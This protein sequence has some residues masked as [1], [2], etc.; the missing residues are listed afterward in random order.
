MKI[1]PAWS[2]YLP[3]LIKV[4]QC[5]EGPVLELGTGLVSTPVLH[6]LCFD[7][8]R[9]LVSYDDPGTELQLIHD[10]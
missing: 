2:S 8:G 5:S 10:L 6:W 7:M 9:E 4:L 1:K 3:L